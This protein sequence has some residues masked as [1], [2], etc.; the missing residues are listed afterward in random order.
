MSKIPSVLMDKKGQYATPKKLIDKMIAKVKGDEHGHVHKVLDPSAGKGDICEAL[1]STHDY[2]FHSERFR[3][4]SA[5][6]IDRDL[7]ATLRGKGIKVIDSDFLLFSG[8]DKFDLIIA[9][10][11]FE[12][13][14]LHLL[15]AIDILY[16]GEIVFLLNAETIKNPYTVSRKEL[17]KKLKELKAEVEFIPNAFTDAERKTDVEVAL[18]YIRVERRVEDDLFQ[19]ATDKAVD[20]KPGIEMNYEV[21]TKH[22]VEELV[23]EYQQVIRLG[24][25]TILGY[26]RHFKKVGRYIGLNKEASKD[27]YR[28]EDPDSLTFKMQ[29]TLNDLLTCAR[30]DFW[31]RTMELREVKQRMTSKRRKEFQD[32]LTKHCEMDFT[33]FN[34]RQFIINLIDGFE[35]TL[36]DAVLEIFD[37]F[38]VAHCYSSGLY[39]DNIHYFNGWKTNKAFK[40]GKKVIIPIYGGYDHGPFQDYSGRWAVQY[41]CKE[42]LRDIDIVMNYFDGLDASYFS[43][44]EALNDAFSRGVSSKIES[45]YFTVTVYK[46][47][48]MHLTFNSEDILRRFNVAA[49]LGK[50]FLPHDYGKKAYKECEPEFKTVIDSFEGSAS[51]AKHLNQPVFPC[52]NRLQIA[53]PVKEEQ[54]DLFAA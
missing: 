6:E 11:P 12:A 7:Q 45:T 42:L 54:L 1:H 36:T 43:I 3:D 30:A 48:T 35:K 15:K 18:V 22:H 16:R 38:T 13:G 29:E 21:S 9:N 34:I 32:Y 25:E 8:P 44:T 49:C 51:Y 19:D 39:D 52:Q 14:D 17:A 40:V 10:P 2:H 46:K 41:D 5:I 4:I 28:E 20:P 50:N 53:A 31:T 33:E 24:T 26:F 37:K 47:G 23:A 27:H